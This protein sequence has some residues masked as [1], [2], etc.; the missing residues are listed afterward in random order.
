MATLAALLATSA[1]ALAAA[2]G[3]PPPSDD[4]SRE[5]T[6]PVDAHRL[7]T[8][9]LDLLGRPP[10]PSERE[11]WLGMEQAAL[12]REL[13]GSSGFWQHWF[14]EQLYYF[15]LID[16]F[17]PRAERVL[18]IPADL[19]RGA[20]DVREAIHLIALS[21]SFDQRNPGADTFVTVVMEQLDGL[22]VKK[23]ARELEVGKAIYDG[24]SGVFLGSTGSN[25]ADVVRIAIGHKLFAQTFVAREYERLL[26]AAPDKAELAAWTREFLK[27]PRVYLDLV[28]RWFAS[29][30]YEARLSRGRSMPNRM[31]VRALFVD[32]R[33][34]VPSP[35]EDDRTRNALDALADPLPLRSVIA[36]LMLDADESAL[37]QRSAISDPEAW[38]RGEYER[39]LGR[40]PT[41]SEL[42][43]FTTAF[44]DPALR[45]STV[46]YALV[47]HAEYQ[48]Y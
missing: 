19:A 34:R 48:S 40:S 22:D 17:E 29:P 14:D 23:S 6:P 28:A 9:S 15:L 43:T 13:I 24:A 30:E 31:F 27:D 12:A 5:A 3:D 10:L 26:G 25:Q 20:L 47:S 33:G 37:P 35:E 42:A 46:V 4:V 44:R 36:R 38:I 39:L 21:S 11:Q 7:R 18:A 16:N 1:G 41:A 45:P 2:Q 8:L 32:L